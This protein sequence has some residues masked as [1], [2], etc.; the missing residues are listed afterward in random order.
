M[1]TGSVCA[2]PFFATSVVMSSH[3]GL[4]ANPTLYEYRYCS[5][6]RLAQTGYRDKCSLSSTRP[7]RQS[8]VVGPQTGLGE[9][10]QLMHGERGGGEPPS[11]L[12]P[13]MGT[14]GSEAVGWPQ[15]LLISLGQ[16]SKG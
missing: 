11:A 9:A 8:N 10:V 16:D 14:P 4:L 12:G 7:P 1:H 5:S 2:F 6:A 15:F 13:D 3:V